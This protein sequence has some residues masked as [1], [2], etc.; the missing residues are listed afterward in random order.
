MPQIP[1]DPE[2]K[3]IESALGELVPVSSRLDRDNL[4]FQAGAM[5]S[6]GAR[7]G[8]VWPACTAALGLVLCGESLLLVSRPAPQVVERVV[9]VPAP[10]SV[11]TASS[12]REPETVAE[13]APRQGSEA[14]RAGESPFVASW[15]VA[16]DFRRFQA[17][18]MRFG[19]DAVQEPSSGAVRTAGGDLPG[20]TDLVRAGAAEHRA[21]EDPQTGRSLMSR[22]YLFLAVMAAAAVAS[23][24]RAYAGPEGDKPTL[25]VLRPAAAPVPALKYQLLPERRSLVAGN[26]ALFYHRATEMSMQQQARDAQV[27]TS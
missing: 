4:M 25:I 18:V 23:D 26:A 9:Y 5:S 6:Q 24:A 14:P 22:R 12:A 3:A 17:M 21:A 27:A 10:G 2:L 11:A 1:P 13:N 7:R 15:P 8:W 16:S 19:L 20:G